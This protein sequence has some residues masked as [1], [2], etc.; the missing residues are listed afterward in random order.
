MPTRREAG[1]RTERFLAPTSLRV[2]RAAVTTHDGSVR[3][4]DVVL[5]IR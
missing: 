4:P 3:L 2:I 1:T 5:T